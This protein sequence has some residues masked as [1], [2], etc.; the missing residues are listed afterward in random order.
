MF[1]WMSLYLDDVA[2]WHATLEDCYR[3]GFRTAGSTCI[4]ISYVQ[5]DIRAPLAF[6]PDVPRHRVLKHLKSVL[7]KTPSP[8]ELDQHSAVMSTEVQPMLNQGVG[9]GVVIGIGFFFA[10]VMSGVSYLQVR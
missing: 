1:C 7:F 10:L 8:K 2:L 4:D 5:H 6:I 3:H 9:Y